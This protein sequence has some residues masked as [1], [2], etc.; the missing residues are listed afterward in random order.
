M[1]TPVVHLPSPLCPGVGLGF[2]KTDW[3]LH[4]L[5]VT[6]AKA[7]PDGSYTPPVFPVRKKAEVLGLTRLASPGLD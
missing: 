2:R 7:S 3:D 6:Y 5:H 1:G 4:H